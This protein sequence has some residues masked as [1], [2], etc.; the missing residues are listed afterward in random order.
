MKP[1]TTNSMRVGEMVRWR[2][3][4]GKR[5]DRGRVLAL[6]DDG[7]AL[8]DVVIPAGYVRSWHL[9]WITSSSD[10]TIITWVGDDAPTVLAV[11]NQEQHDHRP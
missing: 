6:R 1:K 8:V 5:H 2:D 11:L 3:F 4:D 10:P 9:A 7:R